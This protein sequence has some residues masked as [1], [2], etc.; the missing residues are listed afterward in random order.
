MR[1]VVDR[2]DRLEF[3]HGA[4]I[5]RVTKLESVFRRVWKGLLSLALNLSTEE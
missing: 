2:L 3:S 1:L 4:L 5:L